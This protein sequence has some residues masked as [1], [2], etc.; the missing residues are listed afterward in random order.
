MDISD[1]WCPLEGLF[2][3]FIK[4]MDEGIDNI[5]QSTY[6]VSCLPGEW[7]LLVELFPG[8]FE[9]APSPLPSL[10]DWF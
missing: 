10:C 9:A 5:F 7:E 1:Q 2:H 6:H 4:D 8:L 3:I